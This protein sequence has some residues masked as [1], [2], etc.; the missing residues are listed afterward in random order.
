MACLESA[1]VRLKEGSY[2][3]FCLRRVGTALSADEMRP[4]RRYEPN[5]FH[6][7]RQSRQLS[8]QVLILVI[9]Q[10]P[11]LSRFEIDTAAIAILGRSQQCK[12][13]VWICGVPIDRIMAVA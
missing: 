13:S 7:P 1:Q 2:L 9:D 6:Q 4:S 5:P 8:S 11:W 12:T 10:G 3:P